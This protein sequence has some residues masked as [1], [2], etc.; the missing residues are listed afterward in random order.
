MFFTNQL[1]RRR[2]RHIQ[3]Q[4]QHQVTPIYSGRLEIGALDHATKRLKLYHN[5]FMFTVTG[6]EP[7]AYVK[8]HLGQTIGQLGYNG[9]MHRFYR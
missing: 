2:N 9:Q 6:T 1:Q 5:P 4:T 7:G 3:Q 8:N